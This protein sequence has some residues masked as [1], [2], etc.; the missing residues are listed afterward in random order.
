MFLSSLAE[1]GR[2]A[3][4]RGGTNFNLETRDINQKTR[5]A[6]EFRAERGL[7]VS[8]IAAPSHSIRRIGRE[9][10]PTRNLDI[11]GSSSRVPGLQTKRPPLNPLAPDYRLP[12]KVEQPFSAPKFLRDQIGVSDIEGARPKRDKRNDL[13]IPPRVNFTLHS[14]EQK[15][16]KFPSH[17]PTQEKPIDFP[18]QPDETFQRKTNECPEIN[19]DHP[20]FEDKKILV[21]KQ[22]NMPKFFKNQSSN[23]KALLSSSVNPY[24]SSQNIAP[25][26]QKLLVSFQNRNTNF[27]SASTNRQ[28]GFLLSS[29]VPASQSFRS[30]DIGVKER[31]NRLKSRRVTNALE[32]DYGDF[33]GKVEGSQPRHLPAGIERTFGSLVCKDIDGTTPNLTINPHFREKVISS[34]S[35]SVH[36]YEFLRRASTFS[37]WFGQAGSSDLKNDRP[38]EARVRPLGKLHLRFS[39]WL[40]SRR[41]SES[42]KDPTKTDDRYSVSGSSASLLRSTPLFE[43][44]LQQRRDCS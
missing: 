23:L 10:D 19:P 38:S 28:E 5:F 3:I 4:R 21:E 15:R 12:S 35:N 20:A 8:D 13:Q 25:N 14:S 2:K 30:D 24:S 39:T 16:Q 44:H 31:G 34:A 1:K 18:P 33:G 41:A 37:P 43:H 29:K 7:N 36:R 17:S 26:S 32:P 42:K 40:R 9:F 27:Q 11:E 22:E 6:S